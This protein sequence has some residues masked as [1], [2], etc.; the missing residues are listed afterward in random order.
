MK[1][2]C[3]L[4]GQTIAILLM[5]SPLIILSQHSIFS[6]SF[7]FLLLIIVSILYD[8]YM[9]HIIC[10]SN[11][12]EKEKEHY[13]KY[14]KDIN[15]KIKLKLTTEE[16]YKL[17]EE[18][19]ENFF[20]RNT[21]KSNSLFSVVLKE[22]NVK[23]KRNMKNEQ[24]QSWKGFKTFIGVSLIAIQIIIMLFQIY[25][26]KLYGATCNLSYAMGFNYGFNYNGITYAIGH[27]IL[28]ILGIVFIYL[29]DK[30][31]NNVLKCILAII[32]AIIGLIIIGY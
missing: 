1:R 32:V 29:E 21:K 9:Y 23:E 20:D 26:C 8:I 13:Y 24:D 17:L 6:R 18:Y 4:L 14:V 16:K 5:F 27:N 3:I 22:E 30:K 7:D 15:K 31:F 11:I 12:I 10:N 2:V 28:L 25:N 19:I